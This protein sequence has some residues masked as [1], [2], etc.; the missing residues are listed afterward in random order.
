[1]GLMLFPGDDD[2][3][4]PDVSWSYTGF[5]MFR[6][7]LAQTEGFALA[8]MDGFGGER[9]WSSVSTKLEP[10]LNHPDDDGPDLTSA[11]CAAMLPRLEATILDHRLPDP[12]DPVLRRRIEDVSQ[13][14]T[15]LRSCVDKNVDLVFG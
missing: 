6:E 12:S 1:M 5:G 10:L 8:E 3:T 9:D 11:Q 13:L 14:V 7:W 4:S 2:V 15:V